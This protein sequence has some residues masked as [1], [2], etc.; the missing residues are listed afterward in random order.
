MSAPAPASK[1][2]PAYWDGF[3]ARRKEH[4]NDQRI[5]HLPLKWDPSSIREGRRALEAMREGVHPNAP[6]LAQGVRA[7]MDG[8]N[9]WYMQ[10]P[11]DDSRWRMEYARIVA[12]TDERMWALFSEEIEPAVWTELVRL[13]RKE[14]GDGEQT[15]DVIA[16]LHLPTY[17]LSRMVGYARAHARYDNLRGEMAKEN[18]EAE[19]ERRVEQSVKDRAL[20]RSFHEQSGIQDDIM[21]KMQSLRPYNNQG[22]AKD[23]HQLV[24]RFTGSMSLTDTRPIPTRAETKRRLLDL[25]ILMERPMPTTLT[26]CLAL[27]KHYGA[28]IKRIAEDIDP[29]P[30]DKKQREEEEEE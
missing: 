16:V 23:L 19:L 21:R 25:V 28:R 22:E 12:L 2:D 11:D 18:L 4:A 27:V 1:H 15:L 14:T 29:R 7:Y 24:A 8:Y 5:S 10:I 26:E 30:G 3:N 17:V 6:T 9:R 20:A 13:I